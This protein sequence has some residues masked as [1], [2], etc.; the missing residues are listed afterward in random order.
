[1]QYHFIQG[2]KGPGT[3]IKF[4][5][6]EAFRNEGDPELVDSR[7][8][9][10]NLFHTI[11]RCVLVDGCWKPTYTMVVLDS[12]PMAIPFS[13]IDTIEQGLLSDNGLYFT[14]SIKAEDG[15][16][17]SHDLGTVTFPMNPVFCLYL[18]KTALIV[19]GT[20]PFDQAIQEDKVNTCD[21]LDLF[22]GRLFRPCIARAPLV[23]DLILVCRCKTIEEG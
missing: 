1:M 10:A 7:N 13:M 23:H 20:V 4:K 2:G 19:G 18:L 21:L 11:A 8:A 17:A 9:S 15:E 14:M 16:D 3:F 12:T 22:L 5:I 6:P